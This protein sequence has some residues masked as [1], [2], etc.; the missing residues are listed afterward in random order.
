MGSVY[1][2]PVYAGRRAVP[3]AN[4]NFP[5]ILCGDVIDVFYNVI[6]IFNVYCLYFLIVITFERK[7][8]IFLQ[9]VRTKFFGHMRARSSVNHIIPGSRMPVE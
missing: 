6:A 8:K 3:A 2:S 7:W 1:R 4:E 5:C 9:D